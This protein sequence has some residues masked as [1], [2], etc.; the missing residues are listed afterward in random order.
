MQK[1][2][3]RGPRGVLQPF[4]MLQ[5]GCAACRELLGVTDCS[6]GTRHVFPFSAYLCEEG[7][8][9]LIFSFVL[10]LMPISIV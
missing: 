9:I 3:G 5:R 7:V 4:V 8:L 6:P 1:G 10:R 2:K